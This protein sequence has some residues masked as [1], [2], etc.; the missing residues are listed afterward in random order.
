MDNKVHQR[1]DEHDVLTEFTTL[2]YFI[3]TITGTVARL[4]LAKGNEM[5]SDVQPLFFLLSCATVTMQQ[6][7]HNLLPLA[8]DRKKIQSWSNDHPTKHR[9]ILPEVNIPQVIVMSR[10]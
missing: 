6:L 8:I 3:H 2:T 5:V 4:P 10:R 9:A 7:T 1:K